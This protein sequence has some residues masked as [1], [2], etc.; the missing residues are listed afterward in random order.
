VPECP[1]V[2]CQCVVRKLLLL[3]LHLFVLSLCLGVLFLSFV[4]Q[5]KK[6]CFIVD[7]GLFILFVL[8]LLLVYVF[9][10]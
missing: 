3:C 2:E 5:N 9:K 8:L 1:V 10:V 4:F 6:R 7:L